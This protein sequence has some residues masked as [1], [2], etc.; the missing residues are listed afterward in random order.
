LNCQE[1]CLNLANGVIEELE[2]ASADSEHNA[3][4][5]AAFLKRAVTNRLAEDSENISHDSSREPFYPLSSKFTMDEAS[6]PQDDLGEP[7]LI[8]G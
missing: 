2:K 8:L 4:I 6:S 5:F 1:E 3:G 7:P